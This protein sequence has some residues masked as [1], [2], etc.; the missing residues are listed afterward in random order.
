M[1]IRDAILNG[2]Y[3]QSE[4]PLTQKEFEDML[5]YCYERTKAIDDAPLCIGT[6]AGYFKLQGVEWFVLMDD[7]TWRKCEDPFEVIDGKTIS[8]KEVRFL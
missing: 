6:C 8:K 3:K 7:N 1:S 4:T 5:F 2:D